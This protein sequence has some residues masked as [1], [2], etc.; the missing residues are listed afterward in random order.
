MRVIVHI[1][2]INQHSALYFNVS[3]KR[4]CITSHNEET[5]NDFISKTCVRVMMR[6]ETYNSR[7]M[8]LTTEEK[9]FGAFINLLPAV[10]LLKLFLS[11]E[12]SRHKP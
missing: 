10:C 1:C 12:I 2:L 3:Q 5:E 8:C 11:D 7:K 9:C 6:Y 4:K